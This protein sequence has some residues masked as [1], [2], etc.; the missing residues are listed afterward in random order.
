MVAHDS[1]YE[2]DL[3]YYMALYEDK[4][5]RWV[6]ATDKLYDLQ[7]EN[8]KLKSIILK[9]ERKRDEKGRFTK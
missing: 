2:K 8:M 4:L 5:T 6:K 9:L 1:T 3:S 7:I